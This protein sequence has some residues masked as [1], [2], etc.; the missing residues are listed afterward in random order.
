MSSDVAAR[1]SKYG[2]TIYGGLTVQWPNAGGINCITI[3]N[4]DGNSWSGSGLQSKYAR[5][6]SNSGDWGNNRYLAIDCVVSG[7]VTRNLLVLVQNGAA[8]GSGYGH[9]SHGTIYKPSG[10]SFTATCDERLKKNVLPITDALDKLCALQGVSFDWKHPEE[11]CGEQHSQG[12]IA[13]DVVQIFPEW[14]T[15]LNI[16]ATSSEKPLLGGETT[17]LCVNLPIGFD[18][19]LVESIKALR[20]E[21]ENLKARLKTIEQVLGM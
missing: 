7:G 13:Q 21:N 18:A 5:I 10:G 11:H 1:V 2:D 16:P 12:F 17:G 8:D 20:Q 6:Y 15:T 14:V 19:Y 3:E 9:F 4:T